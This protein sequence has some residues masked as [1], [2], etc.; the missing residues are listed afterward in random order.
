M[1]FV[2]AFENPSRQAA[3]ITQD[4]DPDIMLAKQKSSP[5]LFQRELFFNKTIFDASLLFEFFKPHRN[6]RTNVCL[7]VLPFLNIR[8]I[9][10]IEAK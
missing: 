7:L 9:I 8:Y 3:S 2:W 6:L 4:L 5:V 1:F 10:T